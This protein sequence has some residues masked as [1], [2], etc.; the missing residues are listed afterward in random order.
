MSIYDQN[1]K[2]YAMYVTSTVE[3]NCNY[4]SVES[5]AMAGIGIMQWTYGRSWGLLNILITD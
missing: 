4:G 3:T 5:W 2:S 1:W